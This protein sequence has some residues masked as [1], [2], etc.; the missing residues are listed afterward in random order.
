MWRRSPATKGIS[1][2]SPDLDQ[3]ELIV[4]AGLKLR[5]FLG[6]FERYKIM[7]TAMQEV[8]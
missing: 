5:V 6:C 7:N 8:L 2:A 1:R 4:P 3:P